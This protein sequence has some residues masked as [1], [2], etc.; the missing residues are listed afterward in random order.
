MEIEFEIPQGY[1]TKQEL[2]KLCSKYGT[3]D[4]RGSEGTG[5]SLFEVNVHIWQFGRPQPRTMSVSERLA[6]AKARKTAA[7]AKSAATRVLK[8]PRDAAADPG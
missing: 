5:S 2:E 1:Y 6:A 7:K 4:Q 3:A 8:R